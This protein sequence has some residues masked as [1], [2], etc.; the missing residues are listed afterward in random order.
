MK[1]ETAEAQ[2]VAVRALRPRTAALLT[3]SAALELAIGAALLVAPML[4][5]EALLG[6][7]LG[8]PQAAFV[9]RIFGAALLA[10]G[11]TCWLERDRDEA[12]VRAGLVAGLLIYN[13]AAAALLVEAA[14]GGTMYGRLLWPAI[15][16]HAALLMWCTMLVRS[17]EAPA[18]TSP[19]RVGAPRP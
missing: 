11:L 12:D 9:A 16:V 17:A 6:D 18:P 8:S 14:V 19:G 7:G 1:L 5:C 10:I 2:V 4:T 15:V 3:A 13:L